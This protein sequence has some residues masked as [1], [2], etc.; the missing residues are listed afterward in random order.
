MTCP[1]PCTQDKQG[2]P[3]ICN[4]ESKRCVLVNGRKG[5]EVQQ[6]GTAVA[7]PLTATV[8]QAGIVQEIRRNQTATQKFGI[9]G[10]FTGPRA[11]KGQGVY[12]RLFTLR[13]ELAIDAVGGEGFVQAMD[14]AH[15]AGDR[16]AETAAIA[17]IQARDGTPPW[18]DFLTPTQRAFLAAQMAGNTP[19]AATPAAA[20]PAETPAQYRLA[21]GQKRCKA[22]YTQ[23]PPKSG[24]CIAKGAAPAQGAAPAA[25]FT[26]TYDLARERRPGQDTEHMKIKKNSLRVTTSGAVVRARGAELPSRTLSEF[27]TPGRQYTIVIF[28]NQNMIR[29]PSSVGMDSASIYPKC[30]FK[31]AI[32]AYPGASEAFLVTH[33]QRQYMIDLSTEGSSYARVSMSAPRDEGSSG[34]SLK[35]IDEKTGDMFEVDFPPHPVNPNPFLLT[36]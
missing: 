16:A 17:A 35:V 2:R 5:K 26:I 6:R 33:N 11:S 7:T 10:S 30:T 4:P 20:T 13:Q 31:E 28:N 18:A 23:K 9:A 3:Q 21:P 19:A 34:A 12:S 32:E 27:F 36:P 8:R 1:K 24:M 25:K 14:K 15:A 29:H 22:G